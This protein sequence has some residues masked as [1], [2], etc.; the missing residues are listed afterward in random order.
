MAERLD[1][2]ETVSSQELL[3]AQMI[4]LDAVTQLLI[5]KGVFTDQ[6]FFTRLKQVQ[7]DYKSKRRDI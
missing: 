4:Q 5:D 3:M 7:V 1:N 6:E 2:K